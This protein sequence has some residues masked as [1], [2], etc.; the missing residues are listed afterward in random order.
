[1]QLTKFGHSCVRLA[2]RGA[3]LVIDPGTLSEAESVH[4]ADAVLVTHEH[5]DHFSESRLRYACA[6]NPGLEIFSLPSICEALSDLGD[7]VHTVADRDQFTTAG[8]AVRAYVSPHARIHADVPQVGNAGFLIDEAVFHPGDSLALPLV[9]IDTLLVPVH[10]TWTCLSDTIE[11]VRA[12][13]PRRAVAIHDS[14]LSTVGKSIV[15]G[16][17]G[18]NGPGIG[19]AYVHLEPHMSMQVTVPSPRT[20]TE[21]EQT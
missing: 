4:D 10:G 20:G 8:F 19:A 17:L 21:G 7:R 3:S 6:L 18:P 15:D 2:A 9:P 11:W 1:V 13:A 5:F 14:G 12:V 16:F